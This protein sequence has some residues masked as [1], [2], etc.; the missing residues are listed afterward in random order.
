MLILT[1]SIICLILGFIISIVL[2]FFLVPLLKRINISQ[3]VSR[4]LNERHLAKEG[5]P[6]MGG[7]IFII[8]VLLILVFFLLKGSIKLNANFIILIGIFLSYTAL[9][10]IDDYTKIRYK[11]NKGLSILSKFF[12]EI[13]IAVIFFAVFMINGNNTILNVFYFNI[14]LKYFYGFLILLM[15]VGTSNAVNITDGLDGLCAGISAISFVTFGIIAWNSNYIIG[16][17]EIAIFC[18]V[19]AG[20]L[21]GFLFFNFYPAKVFMGDLGSLALGGSLASVA[22]LLKCEIALILIGAVF[23]VE[24]LSSMLQ[25]ISIKLWNKKIFK[26]SPLHHH[27]EELDFCESDII[28]I[29][30]TISLGCNLIALI[31]YVWL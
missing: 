14:D 10:F 31:Y 25:I 12:I 3:S 13:I 23:I 28:K 20:A 30:Y 15:L 11:N 5:T 19:L 21:L 24:T 17:E 4:Y 7:F 27:L 18:F 29:F 1:K 26:K 8:T 2:G 6:T 9:G 16:F 22:I